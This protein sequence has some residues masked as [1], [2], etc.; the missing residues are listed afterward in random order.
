MMRLQTLQLHPLNE[1][2]VATWRCTCTLHGNRE[3]PVRTNRKVRPTPSTHAHSPILASLLSHDRSTSN[4]GLKPMRKLLP[5]ESRTRNPQVQNLAHATRKFTRTS[6]KHRRTHERTHARTH[7]H[8]TSIH[9]RTSASMNAHMHT[10][11]HATR[12]P[13][14]RTHARTYAYTYECTAAP[15]RYLASIGNQVTSAET[16]A[17]NATHDRS[18]LLIAKHEPKQPCAARSP[19]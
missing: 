8:W 17:E 7:D 9:A 13:I 19:N 18:T 5:D 10:Y 6:G 16:R 11:L 3:T 14:P 15:S 12:T 2:S 4:T 1:S